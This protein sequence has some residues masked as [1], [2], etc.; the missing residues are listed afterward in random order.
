VNR[1]LKKGL[2]LKPEDIY[3]AQGYVSYFFGEYTTS[4]RSLQKAS[5]AAPSYA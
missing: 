1:S 4:A 3:A 2:Y 5:D